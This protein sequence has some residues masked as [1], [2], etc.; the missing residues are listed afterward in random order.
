MNAT[1]PPSS[2]S[3]P[4]SGR[5][6]LGQAAISDLSMRWAALN[7]AAALVCRLAG[8]AA[9]TK[10][11]EL[12][13]FP[14]KISSLSGMRLTLAQDGIDDLAALMEPG[15]AALLAVQA[16]GHSPA[17]AALVL[18]REFHAARA[19]LMALVPPQES[20]RVS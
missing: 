17:P 10:T 9:E 15:L 4:G 8:I 13:N 16:R 14:A 7:D 6:E 11:P 5:A 3:L 19:A 2:G 1:T 12:R 18:W 20:F